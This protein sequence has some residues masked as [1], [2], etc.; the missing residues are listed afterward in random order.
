ML[1]ID[2]GKAGTNGPCPSC[3]VRIT[4]PAAAPVRPAAPP[5]DT[6]RTVIARSRKGRVLADTGID[7]AHL[8]NRESLQS[9]KV[10]ALFFLTFC[11]GLAI[12]WLM[13][14]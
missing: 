1:A 10:L 2:A 9:L 3:G 12:V 8:Q 13:S 5:T 6:R 7:H 14:R 11:A 4:A